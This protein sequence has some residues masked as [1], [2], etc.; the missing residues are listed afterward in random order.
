VDHD[1]WGGLCKGI[2]TA[3]DGLGIV[4]SNAMGVRDP[5]PCERV[6]I[7]GELLGM[8]TGG[9]SSKGAG[10]EESGEMEGEE[11]GGEGG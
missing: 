10:T 4:S 7:G 2:G 1:G 11:M 8:A 9:R 3:T 5:E 6:S